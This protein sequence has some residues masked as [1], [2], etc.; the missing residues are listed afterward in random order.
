MRLTNVRAATQREAVKTKLG[1]MIAVGNT[2]VAMGLAW[3]WHTLS[4]NPPFA[5]GVDPVSTNGKKTTKVIVLLTDGDNTNDVT[6]NPNKSI[7]TGYGYIAQGRLK[8]ASG[9]AL[10]ASSSATDRRD[11]IDSREK[12]LCKNAKAE[13]VGDL[14]HRRGGLQPLPDHPPGVR[15][16]AGHVLRRQ[17]RRR[18]DLGVQHHRRLDPE[19]ADHRIGS[20]S[21]K[22]VIAGPAR[23]AP[24]RDR[25]E[26][27]RS[28][29]VPDN[30][31]RRFRDDGL[32]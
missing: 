2:N 7:Y 5:D 27:R 4:N 31:S 1:Q 3:S 19:P 6:N 9:T 26:T 17:R 22:I 13:G 28:T 18:T 32:A 25:P 15:H 16:Q 10:T 14:R 24:I 23:G 21:R 8:N 12:L 29:S 30:G 11:A 20:R